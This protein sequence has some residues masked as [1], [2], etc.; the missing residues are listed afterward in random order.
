MRK[1][2]WI[3]SLLLILSF[4]EISAQ[5]KKW[6]LEDCINYAVTNNIGLQRQRLQTEVSEANLL[7][8]KMDVLPNLNFGSDARVGFGRS[9]DPVTNLITFK[10]NLSNS[11][12]LNSNIELFN[13]FAT[14]NTIAANKF[15]LKAGLETEKVT[16]NTLIV[17]I[18]GQ[19]YQVLYTKGLENAS[20]MQLDLSEKQLFRIVKMVE[21]GKE[22]LSRQYEIESQVSADKLAY[23]IALNTA[24]Q[25]LTTLKQMLQLEPGSDFDILLPDLNNVLI[26]DGTFNSDSIYNIAAQTLPRL[27]A[28]EYELK[29]SKKQVSAAKGFLAPRLSV[30][31]AVFTGYYKV[32]SEGAAD[33]ESFSNQLKNNNS[34]AVFLSLNVPIFNNYTTGKNIKLAKIRKNDN[35]LRLEL[36]RNNL[37]TEIENACLN[38]NRG[39]DEFAAAEANFEYNKKSFDAV[40]KKFES[41]LVDVTD[42][43]AAKT[44]LFSADTE[45]LRTKLQLLIRKLTIQFYSTG[46]YENFV[47]K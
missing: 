26:I 23:T 37:Y 36:E 39:K 40:E 9:I 16:K 15:M 5:E 27:K 47:T 34:Q 12:S 6:T 21:T 28:I 4:G 8:S 10:Q 31:G 32:I 11:Y 2:N 30:G 44:T 20:K 33:Q 13:G 38:F 7:K 18:M 17:D 14:L 1:I 42:Y 29:A 45:A 35:E 46:E 41:G 19:Y 22:A 3:L 25:A 24:S 43:S